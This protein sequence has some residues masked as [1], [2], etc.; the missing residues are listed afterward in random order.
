MWPFLVILMIL[1]LL[2]NV[3]FSWRDLTLN[4][5]FLGYIGELPGNEHLWFLTVLIACYVE[6]IFL[7][8]FR[9]SWKWF[10]WAML[11]LMEGL[12]VGAEMK[13]LPGHTFSF[14]GLYGFIFLLG[15]EFIKVSKKLPIWAAIAIVAINVLHLWLCYQG[16][17]EKSRP[18]T[19]LLSDVC[20]LSLLMLMLR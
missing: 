2:L 10:P 13:R 9:P 12:M 20:G 15:K 7:L 11:L 1:Y 17:F 18:L 4:F 5:F 19:F 16:L 6:M 14:L 3:Q 8:K